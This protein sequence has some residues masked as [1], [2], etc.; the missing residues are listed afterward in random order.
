ME[1][2]R[3]TYKYSVAFKQKVI[4]EIETGQI[5]SVCEAQRIY[6]IRGNGT[7][8]KWIR[9][10]GKNELIG[11]VVRVEMKEE[12]DKLKSLEQEKRQLERALAQAHIKVVALESLIEVAE[13][14]YGVDF[15]K[16]FT[17]KP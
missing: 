2:R 3:I 12:K 1:E 10:L 15:K 6:D 11:K 13:E 16:N 17:A 9:K 5:S 14:H 4:R 8:Q 7:I